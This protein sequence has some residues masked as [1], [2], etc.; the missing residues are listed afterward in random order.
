MQYRKFGARLIVRIDRGEELLEKLTQAVLENGVRLAAVSGIGALSELTVGVYDVAKQTYR[1]NTFT[2][3]LEIV[4]LSGSVT[5]KDG[6]PYLHLHLSAG[7]EQGRVFGGHLN[8]AVISATCELI[9]DC[10]DGV[11]GR[12]SDPETGLNLFCFDQSR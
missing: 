7:D 12:K 9:L 3:D 11:V 8:R 6:A 4:S 10:I 1:A 2:G 5:Q